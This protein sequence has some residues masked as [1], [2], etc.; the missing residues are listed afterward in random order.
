MQGL[1]SSR[2]LLTRSED[3]V[4]TLRGRPTRQYRQRIYPLSHFCA[5]IENHLVAFTTGVT[6]RLQESECQANFPKEGFKQTPEQL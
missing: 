3:G 4:K 1:Q 5:G 2:F 6:V